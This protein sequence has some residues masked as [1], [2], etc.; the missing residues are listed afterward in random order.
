MTSWTR[1]SLIATPLP[2][3]NNTVQKKQLHLCL[4]RFLKLRPQCSSRLQ[5]CTSWPTKGLWSERID[6]WNVLERLN[7]LVNR[8]F[9]Q[10]RTSFMRLVTLCRVQLSLEARDRYV[11]YDRPFLAVLLIC[12]YMQLRLDTPWLKKFECFISGFR[13]L[14][15]YGSKRQV[16]NMK[17][18]MH[19]AWYKPRYMYI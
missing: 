16:K 14:L 1:N 3:Q 5:P 10:E 18:A 19:R 8:L 12:S 9:L 15:V 6:L 13:V 2:S 7:F 4:E 17:S 11:H